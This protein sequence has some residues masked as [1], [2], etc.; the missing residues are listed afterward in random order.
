MNILIDIGHPAHVHLFKNFAWAMVKKG[1]SIF[2][3][4]R[5]K[6]FEIYLLEKYGFEYKSFG[7]KYK[8]GFGKIWGMIEFDIKELIS[9][10]KIK[11]DLL[12]SHGSIY[13]AHT[14]FLLR[15]PH[16]SFEDTFNFEQIRLYLP[17][18]NVVLT[19]N[20][21]HPSLN[22]KEIKYDGYHELAYLHPNYFTPDKNILTELNVKENDKYVIIRF[23]SWQATHDAGHK[24]ISLKNKINAVNEFARYAKVFISAETELPYELKEYEINISP[25]RMHDAMYYSTLI[26]G[27]SATMASEGAVLGVPAIYIDNTSRPYTLEQE[28]KYGLVYNFSE[29]EDDQLRAL[30]KAIELLKK[31]HLKEEWKKRQ[32]K[33]LADKIDVT[34]FM[35]WFVAN[36]PKSISVIRGNSNYKQRFR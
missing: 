23:V 16:I 12:L 33:M 6:E 29:S 17:F 1:H 35:V 15:K 20:Y 3:T 14:S 28:K 26:Y 18:T 27:E 10:L 31:Q 9:G 30:E 36:Y 21:D 25:H 11:P 5:E 4:C 32:Q 19:G 34:A 2:F 8:S 22:K 7:K 24:G 13:A